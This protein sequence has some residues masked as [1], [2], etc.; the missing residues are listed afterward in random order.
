MKVFSS[1]TARVPFFH[2][3]GAQDQVRKWIGWEV[4]TTK[5]IFDKNEKRPCG[6]TVLKTEP[7]EIPPTPDYIKLVQCGDLIPAD[8]E[9][10]KICSMT[11]NKVV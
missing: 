7:T 8:E 5:G 10:A 6:V 1:P 11:W 3:L 4:D 9:T 2:T